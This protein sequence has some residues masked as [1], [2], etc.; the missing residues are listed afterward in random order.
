MEMPDEIYAWRNKY[1][2][3]NFGREWSDTEHVNPCVKYTRTPQWQTI[4]KELLA[5]YDKERP[6]DKRQLACIAHQMEQLRDLLPAPPE[7]G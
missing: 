1:S 2:S 5:A 3:E 6:N 7:V 4:I